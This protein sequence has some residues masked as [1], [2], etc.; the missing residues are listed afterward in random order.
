MKKT[1]ITTTYAA[2]LALVTVSMSAS[3]KTDV[4]GALQAL[5]TNEENA[6]S[7]HKQYQENEEISSKNIVE[8]TAAIKQL[9]DQKAQL[10]GNAANLQKNLA[11]LDKMKERLQTFSKEEATQMKKE[12]AQIAQ[13]KA[14]LEKLEANKAKREQNIES[15]TNKIAEVDQEK[16]Q[17][18]E[19]HQAFTAIQRELASKETKALAEREKWIEKRKGYRAEATKW[20]KEAQ[21]AEQTR[22]KYDK[23]KD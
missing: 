6:K 18:A 12:E 21:V 9:R 1:R 17:W 16:A 14:T 13:L 15:Y 7:N 10:N 2:L 3:A 11:I 22:V 20:E 19:Q 4:K 8:V 23:L 5:K